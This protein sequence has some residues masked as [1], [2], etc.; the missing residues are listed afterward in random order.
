MPSR[1]LRI[2]TRGSPMALRQTTVVHDRLVAAHP[3]LAANGAIVTIRTAGDR[4]PGPAARRD[5]RQG[6][7]SSRRSRTR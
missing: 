1:H 6:A 5:R 7:C 2:G 4:V 3:E